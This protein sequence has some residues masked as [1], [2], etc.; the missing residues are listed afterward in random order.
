M[1]PYK[2]SKYQSSL[3]RFLHLALLLD[4]LALHKNLLLLW[5]LSHR[6]RWDN[7]A[8]FRLYLKHTSD[9]AK[10]WLIKKVYYWITIYQTYVI[11]HIR[12]SPI[13][14]SNRNF[15][16]GNHLKSNSCSYKLHNFGLKW[17]IQYNLINAYLHMVKIL[18]TEVRWVNK[19]KSAPADVHFSCLV[20]FYFWIK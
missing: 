2:W 3:R 5:I 16:F 17:Y 20:F 6:S 18:H 14:R 15:I 8:R 10:L 12:S 9:Y 4:Q 13:V 1:Y 19:W 11:H 7:Y